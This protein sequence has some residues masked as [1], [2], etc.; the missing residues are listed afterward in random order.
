MLRISEKDER[1]MRAFQRVHS[2]AKEK[3][4][5]RVFRSPTLFEDCVKCI[6]L[7]NCTLMRALNMARDLC[8]LQSEL[9][10]GLI[11]HILEPQPNGEEFISNT[12][13][14]GLKRKQCTKRKNVKTKMRRKEATNIPSEVN[15][16]VEANLNL[17][18]SESNAPQLG[19]FPSSKELAALNEEIL[20]NHCK[21]GF[22][23]R[24]ILEL[25]RKFERGN[26]ELKKFNKGFDMAYEKAYEKLRKIKGFG[27]FACANAKMCTGFYQEVSVDSETLRHMREQIVEVVSAMGSSDLP[28]PSEHPI[29]I[30]MAGDLRSAMAI[31]PNRE[32][33]G[34]ISPAGLGF[35]CAVDG[36]SCKPQ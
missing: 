29:A 27:P 23:A 4:F 25:A 33:R 5:G 32:G 30:A 3:G 14:K 24:S 8:K 36:G 6:L 9:T 35:G 19:N 7:C 34:E 1:N 11:S 16:C 26:L 28:L 21:L 15:K 10:V 12:M 17:Q 22:R 18:M 31:E 2:R 20:K 13:R